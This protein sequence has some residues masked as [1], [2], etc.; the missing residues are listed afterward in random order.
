MADARNNEFLRPVFMSSDPTALVHFTLDASTDAVEVIFQAD[1]AATITR[2]GFRYRLRTGTPPTFKISL[3]GVDGTG[4]PDGTIKGGG[5][6]AS[7][8]FIPPADTSWDGTWR[9][10]TLDNAYVCTR[11]EFLAIV[12]KHESGT[13]DGSNKSEFT[14]RTTGHYAHIPYAIDNNAGART[15][16]LLR[17]AIF[18][19]ASAAKVYGNP[20]ANITTL[21]FS[22]TGTPDEVGLLFTL[23]A[24]WGDT[25]KV[26]GL[27]FS[28]FLTAAQSYKAVLYD[29][30]TALQTITLDSDLQATNG[31]HGVQEILFTETTLADLDFGSPYRVALQP[32]AAGMS[33]VLGYLELSAAGDLDAYPGGQDAIW[34]QRADLGAWSEPTLRRPLISLLLADWTEPAGGGGSQGRHVGVGHALVGVG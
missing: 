4:I 1:E 22:S 9:W 19:Y 23:P 32:Q 2:L 21:S 15:R 28:G 13:I 24:G 27:R 8:T 5:T 29:G 33:V 10:I 20:V 31:S 34:T 7:A 18:G 11:G 17:T 16:G 3:Q 14:T 30:T 25:F 6:P 12:I 26:K